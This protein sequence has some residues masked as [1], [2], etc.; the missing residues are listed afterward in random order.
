MGRTKAKSISDSPRRMRPALNPDARENQLISLAVD[1]AEKQLMEGTASPSVIAHF[2]KQ[3][4]LKERLE[5]ERL[6]EENKL[7]RAKTEALQS[8][9]R[10]ESLYE[11]A[12]NAMKKYSGNGGEVDEYPENED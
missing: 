10:L 1:L 4:S 7:L 8:T 9:Q 12:L 5:R 2:L 3:G 11:N 6:E